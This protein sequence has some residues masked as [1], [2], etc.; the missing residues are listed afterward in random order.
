MLMFFAIGTFVKCRCHLR[1]IGLCALDV[2]E[3]HHLKK[4]GD[5]HVWKLSKLP[6]DSSTVESYS[7]SNYNV[8]IKLWYV[9]TEKLF[10]FFAIFLTLSS[11]FFLLMVGEDKLIPSSS[12]L[13]VSIYFVDVCCFS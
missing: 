10:M 9:I 11:S 7:V 3:D 5:D 4:E 2:V 13:P 8:A 12:Y 1:T 6:E